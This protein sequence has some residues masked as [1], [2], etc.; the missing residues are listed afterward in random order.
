M[1]RELDFTVVHRAGAENFNVDCLSTPP[2]RATHGISILH[3]SRGDYNFTLASYFAMMAQEATS[4]LTDAMEREIWGDVHVLHF[5]QTPKYGSGLNAT[6][7]TKQNVGRGRLGG[8]DMTS[9]S[10]GE[11]W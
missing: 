9:S 2:L 3:W 11:S 4:P 8:W 7:K 1:L 5:L 10:S 6:S